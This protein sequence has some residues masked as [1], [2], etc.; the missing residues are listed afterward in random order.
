MEKST[1]GS[2]PFNA[3][4]PRDALKTPEGP[5]LLSVSFS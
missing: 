3:V 4:D 2:Q 5:F 1:P